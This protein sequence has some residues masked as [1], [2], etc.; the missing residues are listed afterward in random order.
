MEG[1][2]LNIDQENSKI[3][4]AAADL[5]SDSIEQSPFD[6]L[7]N[8]QTTDYS[9]QYDYNNNSNALLEDT[10]GT[11]TNSMDTQ[12]YGGFD[13]NYHD[14]QY[15][16]GTTESITSPQAN[17]TQNQHDYTGYGYDSALYTNG[18]DNSQYYYSQQ[19]QYY[20]PSQQQYDPYYYQNYNSNQNYD[21]NQTYNL[22]QSFDPSQTYDQSH[23]DPSLYNQDPSAYYQ[24]TQQS[25][26]I[27][28]SNEAN[29][30]NLT[31]DPN[32]NEELSNSKQ[33][34]GSEDTFNNS[35][36]ILNNTDTN[37]VGEVGSKY[38]G[39]KQNIDDAL[40]LDAIPSTT[41]S[42]TFKKDNENCDFSSDSD[43][44][45]NE[46]KETFEHSPTINQD[47]DPDFKFLTISSSSDLTSS[48][49]DNV[50]AV[51][52]VE[53]IETNQE[54][55]QYTV[56]S[57][58]KKNDSRSNSPAEKDNELNGLENEDQEVNITYG[59]DRDI[60][61]YQPQELENHPKSEISQVEK[62]VSSLIDESKIMSEVS[63]PGETEEINDKPNDEP[64]KL[65]DL[66][67]L[68]LGSA[69][70]SGNLEL[71]GG[72]IHE[73]HSIPS[74][75]NDT[76]ALNSSYQYEY[77]GQY[78]YGYEQWGSNDENYQ[79]QGYDPNHPSGDVTHTE[80]LNYQYQ[81]YDASQTTRDTTTETDLANYQYNGYDSN[82]TAAEPP[83]TEKEQTSYLYSSYDTSQ[84][85]VDNIVATNYQYPAY[86][87]NQSTAIETVAEAD[88]S[89]YQYQ[90]YNM[91]EI[92][93]NGK[94]GQGQFN[95]PYQG[96]ETGQV[97][98]D[99]K[100]ET[101]QA[102]YQ[103]TTYDASQVNHQTTSQ[104]TV[105][106]K[107]ETDQSN[108]YQ[109]YQHVNSH[110]SQTSPPPMS[111]SPKGS[112]LI[113]CPYPQC[114]GENKSTAKFCSDCGMQI[115]NNV[116]RSITPAI[117]I[118]EVTNT[119][120]YNND[121]NSRQYSASSF[122]SYGNHD[123]QYL[124]RDS[125]VVL[126]PL[127]S[128]YQQ[129]YV[130]DDANAANDPLG[131]TKG[132][133]PIIA[134][135]FGGK[136]FTM[137]PRTVQRFTSAD[138]ST[139][140]TKYAPGVFTVRV[141]NDIIPVSDI[142]DFPGP[143]LMDNNRGGVKAKRKSV[144]KYLND[145]IQV[146]E[147][148]L[149]SFNGEEIE[150]REL[151]M[152]IIIWNLFKIMFENDGTLIGSSKVEEL[153][154]NILVPFASKSDNDEVNFTVPADTSFEGLSQISELTSLTYS[155][156]PK[157]VDKLQELLL[158]GDRVVAINHAM[159]ENLWA[160]ALIIASCVNKDLW[161]EVVT[162][163]IKH[164]M[165]TQKG[166]SSESNGRESLRVLYSLFAGQ[167][168][169][170][171]KE[172]LP[173]SNLLNRVTQSPV[174]AMI[175]TLPNA[176]HYN[177]NTNPPYV[178]ASISTSH[179]SSSARDVP[180]DSLVKWRETIAMILANRAPGDNQVI[181]AL[182][183]MLKEFG[184]IHAAHI[185]YMLSPKVSIISGF[186]APNVRFTLLGTDSH[187]LPISNFHNWQSLRMTEIY[188]FGLSLNNND[189]G[190]PHL[191]A[192]KLLYAWWL[193]DCGYLNESRRYCES[194]ANIVKVYTKGSP[195][196][197]GCFLQKLKDLTQRL[198][199]H[200]G[201]NNGVNE[202]S[203]WLFAK[204]M[205][206]ATLDSLWGSLE[207]K[208]HKFVAGDTVDENVKKTSFSNTKE[209]VGPFSHFSSITH[210]T[211]EVPSRSASAS[212]FRSIPNPT[213]DT[214]RATTPNAIIYKQLNGNQ[215]RLS[216][217][218]GVQ[219]ESVNSGYN[220]N[221][222][223]TTSDG[224]NTMSSVPEGGSIGTSPTDIKNE[225]NNWQSF[226]IDQQYNGN[227][228][229]QLSTQSYNYSLSDSS[230]AEA[231]NKQKQQAMY[232]YYQPL[233]NN[234]STY[235]NDSAW[236]SNPN[237]DST[238]DQNVDQAQTDVVGGSE[239]ISPMDSSGFTSFFSSPAPAPVVATTKDSSN[240]NNDFDNVDDDL[241]LGN[242]AFGTK[243]YDQTADSEVDTKTYDSETNNNTPQTEKHE[244]K[245]EDR[246]EEK[247]GWFGRWFGKKESG[248]KTA[249]LGEESSFYFDPVQKRWI[250]KKAGSETSSAST[251]LP[252][253]PQRSKTTSP[254][255]SQSLMSSNSRQSL[256][257]IDNKNFTGPPISATPPPPNKGGRASSASMK[258]RARSKYVDIMNQPPP[259]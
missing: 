82:Q 2:A 96:H 163:F 162:G 29:L 235:T 204:K 107:V 18:Q 178:G 131:R 236:W 157:A 191:Q 198:L 196:F 106:N 57:S 73:G 91:G 218:T 242:N 155:V 193:A 45:I 212:D 94:D 37:S 124:E 72:N 207:G 237:A 152:I 116:M 56:T 108:Y 76:T 12:L 97:T 8:E 149:N 80:Q 173:Y 141:L 81:G 23:Y 181:S 174:S 185:C 170:A 164:E 219:Y 245:Q 248:G 139:P 77:S 104:A 40:K 69:N 228:N 241:G 243:N 167:G 70:K 7:V 20:D 103:Y 134:L 233:G 51:T 148:K 231:N 1:N 188:E 217:P 58:E 71:E 41:F 39:S 128:D 48:H 180:L 68:V 255:R 238:V 74:Q 239:F 121:A 109:G 192:Y 203:S 210:P 30:Q 123:T 187:N 22:N 229:E 244:A 144:L 33:K 61:E 85:G 234:T 256:P 147:T 110:P 24:Y 66:D 224:Q 150:K 206:K 26:E 205:P 197:H 87:A 78:N 38:D 93:V 252:P 253:P 129:H 62:S 246:K 209:A 102:N 160:H 189:G 176:S 75:N 214:R 177:S 64:T 50:A 117:S 225:H 118:S 5:F 227:S 14:G 257:P 232:P 195:Y 19:Q 230:N 137:F 86:E 200:G 154:R 165:G 127:Q 17:T 215:R 221:F 25:S 142:T 186:D 136:M 35:N 169:N 28:D 247:S 119:E 183:D 16:N 172:F 216:T 115:N 179:S 171:A 9:S 199:E 101:S 220:N 65:D 125:G 6:S 202:T 83:I 90:G 159:N 92:A 259:N 140:I 34:E 59:D 95:Y 258:K 36:C 60:F 250:N 43:K 132:C 100:D 46:N 32:S 122:A 251:P 111:P 31:L 133:R 21:P 120:I 113:S 156:S 222:S 52:L 27:N 67:D 166:D 211:S 249:N 223:P 161:K 213:I 112:N 10:R 126:D 47:I 105:N 55:S 15:V 4:G 88:Q 44:K 153:V 89:N 151:E 201:N 42:D 190:L 98:I 194:I 208:F 63:A 254:Q 145:Q 182:G 168:Q 114:G 130:T 3:A 13:Y 135:G 11:V 138:Q 49:T 240:H 79:S 84:A 99:N 143:L 158:K 54:S 184:W 53:T 146:T 226:N 175:P